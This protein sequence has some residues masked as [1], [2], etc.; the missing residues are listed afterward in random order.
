MRRAARTAF[1]LLCSIACIAAVTTADAANK[2]R[3]VYSFQG[4][5]DGA[6]PQGGLLAVGK[7]L[8]GTTLAGG[9]NGGG[10]LFS[11]DLKTGTEKI[12]H[13]FGTSGD[14][15]APAASL[16]KLGNRLFGTA[17]SGGAGGN[18]T[19]FSLDLKTGAVQTV[20]S[21]Q[22]GA[23]DGWIPQSRLIAFGGLLYGTTMQGGSQACY[24]W[25]CGTIFSIDPATGAE[26]IAYFFQ[27]GDGSFPNAGLI[28][29]GKTLYG[30][31]LSGG[32]GDCGTVF[33]F[34]PATGKETVIHDFDRQ[35]DGTSPGSSL[36]QIDN[37]LYGTTVEGGGRDGVVYALDRKT[38]AE[39][40]VHT[41]S[42]GDGAIP[43]D[44]P[45]AVGD[46]LYVTASI[47]GSANDGTV[48]ALDT[49]THAVRVIH[50][51]TGADGANPWANLIQVGTRLYGTA[52]NGGAAG[53]G[54]I[55]E[56]K[57]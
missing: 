47:G 1:G 20:Y 11:F 27:S 5:S 17:S 34:D 19:V 52:Y 9:S 38:E 13:S 12:L 56:I 53:G 15:A 10:T 43:E 44:S 42:G 45:L 54:A 35:G 31:T 4:G 18:G 57:P 22:G 23:N 39:Q 21:F 25:G 50:T 6:N 3:L 36:A 32:G 14:G 55:F 41:Y 40:V 30:T 7:T 51:F 24:L 26:K 48:L 29:I 2:F 46:T 8:Y 28:K 33:T 37:V 49:D 16:V